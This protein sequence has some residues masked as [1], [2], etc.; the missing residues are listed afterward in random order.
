MRGDLIQEQRDADA[1]NRK[2][3]AICTIKIGEVQDTLTKAQEQKADDERQLPLLN[4]EQVDK[5]R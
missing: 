1:K 2:E 5:Q 3:S 4:E